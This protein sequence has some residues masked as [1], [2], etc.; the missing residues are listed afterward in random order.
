[1]TYTCQHQQKNPEVVDERRMNPFLSVHGIPVYF[2][3]HNWE[4]ETIGSGLW[5][6]GLALSQ[7]FGTEAAISNLQKLSAN[8][9]ASPLSSQSPSRTGL[10]ILELGSGNG[11]LAVCVAAAASAHGVPVQEMVV[12]DTCDH[13][14]LIRATIDANRDACFTTVQSLSVQEHNWGT[15]ASINHDHN[16]HDVDPTFDLIVGSDLAYRDYLY[17][18][19]IQSIGHY[20]HARTVSLIGV[21]MSDT[22]ADFFDKLDQAGFRYQKLADHLIQPQFRGTTFGIFVVQKRSE[23]SF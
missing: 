14:D 9:T 10:K 2:K 21:T 11:F 12:T 20:S 5:S 13:L 6:T 22:K 8:V 16:G 19:L 15:F 1:M 4:R 17:D 7:Y 18:P 23:Y 3:E